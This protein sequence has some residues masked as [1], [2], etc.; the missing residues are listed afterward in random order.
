MIGTLSAIAYSQDKYLVK[1]KVLIENYDFV[2]VK[3]V[4][5]DRYSSVQLDVSNKGVFIVDLDWNKKYFFELSK[6]GYVSKIVEFSTIIPQGRSHSIEPFDMAVK[7]FPVFEG[8]DSVFFR[9][10]VAKVYYDDKLSDFTDDR[11]YALKVVYRI[12]QM[13]KKSREIAS[14]NIN[15]QKN[16]LLKRSEK[17]KVDSVQNFGSQKIVKSYVSRSVKAVSHKNINEIK[18]SYDLIPLKKTYP[19][20]RTIETFYVDGKEITRVVIRKGSIQNVFFQV[21]HPWGGVFYFLDETP[22]GIF[23]VTKT[24][25]MWYTGLSSVRDQKVN[26]AMNNN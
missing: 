21:K 14:N 19:E 16:K 18:S 25:F 8:V 2:G 26:V 11:D 9:K 7:L 24:S 22:L 3:V 1:G 5:T 10:P 6:P 12:K 17:Q 4:L 13:L 23:S 15:T 20:G